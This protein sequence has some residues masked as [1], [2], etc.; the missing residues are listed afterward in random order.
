MKQLIP[1]RLAQRGLITLSIILLFAWMPGSTHAQ[2]VH[3]THTGT[4]YHIAHCRYLQRSDY[5]CTLAEALN[6]GL[7]PCSRCNPPTE[8]EKKTGA[9]AEPVKKKKKKKNR[10]AQRII[11]RQT[12]RIVKTTYYK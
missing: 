5:T 7:G 9:V 11:Y 2:N 4:K 6:K 8:I 1:A 10:P 3:Y 12:T